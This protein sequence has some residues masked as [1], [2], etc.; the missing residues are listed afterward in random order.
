MPVALELPGDGEDHRVHVL[1]VDRAAAPD[2]AVP[3]SPENGCTVHSAG[4]A[5]TTSR[6]PWIS[7]AP[8]SASAPS[9]RANTLPRPGAPDSTYSGSIA[10]LVELLGH[11]ARAFGLALGGLGFVGVGRVEP[12]QLAD[13]LDDLVARLLAGS[14][15]V[16]FP[17][18]AGY[19]PG[20]G[21]ASSG[22]G[23][24]ADPIR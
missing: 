2:V 22:L 19:R 15:T 3:T 10:D 5:G 14:V 20:I 8:R 11:P 7:S 12:D 21:P 6:W 24:G 4:S 17:T 18:T 23:R 1:H 9:S 16:T 13:E